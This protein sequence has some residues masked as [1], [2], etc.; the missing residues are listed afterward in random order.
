MQFL[1]LDLKEIVIEEFRLVLDSYFLNSTDFYQ[2]EYLLVG[3]GDILRL[4]KA[5]CHNLEEDLTAIKS[6]RNNKINIK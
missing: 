5:N 4:R 1:K 2:S 3:A 6:L